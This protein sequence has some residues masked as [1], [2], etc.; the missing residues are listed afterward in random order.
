MFESSYPV[1]NT[2]GGADDPFSGQPALGGSSCGRGEFAGSGSQGIAA[3]GLATAQ[4]TKTLLGGRIGCGCRRDSGGL[5]GRVAQ[6]A[7]TVG[8]FAGPACHRCRALGQSGT[9]TSF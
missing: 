8:K 2:D 1:T 4:V 7:K 3:G 6:G 9:G 5:G